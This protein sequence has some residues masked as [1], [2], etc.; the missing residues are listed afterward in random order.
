MSDEQVRACLGRLEGKV[1]A[2]RDELGDVAVTAA[3]ISE[4]LSAA[5]TTVTRIGPLEERVV[6]LETAARVVWAV[7]LSLPGLGG[8][9]GWL[10]GRSE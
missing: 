5:E 7:V 2:L 9:V 8:I 6:R 1:D 4:R 3:R 10:L